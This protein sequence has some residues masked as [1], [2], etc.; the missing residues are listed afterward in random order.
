MTLSNAT[1][2]HSGLAPGGGPRAASRGSVTTT[3]AAQPVPPGET[4]THRTGTW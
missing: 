2:R 3:Q 4:D 1:P